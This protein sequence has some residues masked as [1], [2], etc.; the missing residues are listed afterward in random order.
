MIEVELWQVVLFVLAGVA[1]GAIVVMLYVART[2]QRPGKTNPASIVDAMPTVDVLPAAPPRV[3]EADKAA[4]AL[5]AAE[6]RQAKIKAFLNK[7]ILSGRNVSVDEAGKCLSVSPRRIRKLMDTSVLIPIPTADGKRRVSAVSVLDLVVRRES[8][9]QVR[10]EPGKVASEL[11]KGPIREDPREEELR[12]EA[13]PIVK[14]QDKPAEEPPPS[15]SATTKLEPG[16][17]QRYWYHVA[18]KEAPARSLRE[19]L[20]IIG[21]GYAY[22][23]WGS[24]PASVKAKI[25]REKVVWS[26]EE[27]G[28]D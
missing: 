15:E 18:G 24:V 27:E 11:A 8:G 16:P 1:V 13:P 5:S 21:L 28:E 12:E 3:V 4:A 22:V 7:R 26:E 10:R 20:Q 17:N 9:V 19:A 14:P 23:D 6:T 25:R 2:K